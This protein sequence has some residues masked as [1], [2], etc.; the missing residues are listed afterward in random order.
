MSGAARRLIREGDIVPPLTLAPASGG[1]EVRLPGGHQASLLVFAHPEACRP[2]ADYLGE[3]ADAVEDLRGWGTRLVAVAPPDPPDLPFPVVGDEG[4]AARRRLGIGDDEA[5]VVLADRWGEVFE[6]AAI[7]DAHDFPLPRHLIESAKIVD[8][9][10][11]ECN[12]PSPE[13]RNADA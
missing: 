5:A 13:W 12:V 9:S 7:D 4:G 10:C 2:C 3:L 11:G 6:V 8:V 1:A